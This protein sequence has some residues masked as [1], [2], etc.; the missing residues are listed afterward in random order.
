MGFSVARFILKIILKILQVHL[1]KKLQATPELRVTYL[2][3]GSMVAMLC[4]DTRK[5]YRVSN[6]ITENCVLYFYEGIPT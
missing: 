6:Q 3:V 2:Q 5:M 1:K 4:I